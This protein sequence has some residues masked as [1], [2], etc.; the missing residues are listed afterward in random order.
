M[1]IAKQTL[2]LVTTAFLVAYGDGSYSLPCRATSSVTSGPTA[3]KIIFKSGLEISKNHDLELLELLEMSYDEL[4]T[5]AGLSSVDIANL[6]EAALDELCIFGENQSRMLNTRC[7]QHLP[8][9]LTAYEPTNQVG[10]QNSATSLVNCYND[11]HLLHIQVSGHNQPNLS[12]PFSIPFSGLIYRSQNWVLSVISFAN[13]RGE[14]HYNQRRALQEILFLIKRYASDRGIVEPVFVFNP[15]NSAVYETMFYNNPEM[16]RTLSPSNAAEQVMWNQTLLRTSFGIFASPSGALLDMPTLS[17]GMKSV[18]LP[19]DEF[20]ALSG[21]TLDELIITD[22]NLVGA[23]A[24]PALSCTRQSVDEIAEFFGSAWNVGSFKCLHDACVE[25]AFGQAVANNSAKNLAV[26]HT[27]GRLCQPGQREPAHQWAAAPLQYLRIRASMRFSHGVVT[28]ALDF[29][30]SEFDGA[31]F[32]GVH[33]RRGDRLVYS[34]LSVDPETVVER[35]ME[36]CAAR[37]LFNVYL[38]TNCGLERDVERIVAGLRD[39]GITVLRAARFPDWREEDKRLALESAI[40]SFAEHVLIS[41]SAV[42]FSILE[43]RILL[44]YDR[45]TWGELSEG[46]F[47]QQWPA[48]QRELAEDPT[49]REAVRSQAGLG[50]RALDCLLDEPAAACAALV[51]HSSRSIAD[52]L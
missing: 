45:E 52:R 40:V 42:S 21:Q 30:K 32:L 29:I 6:V 19:Y 15:R 36:A 14:L 24:Q 26:A 28:L 44:G 2:A 35:V 8:L 34:G 4:Q 20:R 50:R 12:I 9:L 31:P 23:A 48:M 33:W 18:V 10:N 16:L 5:T 13:F 38:M 39:V 37:Y 17:R 47:G 49:L 7:V 11:Y 41:Q 22:S 1:Q 51:V 25:S 46:E 3:N 27:K 43:E